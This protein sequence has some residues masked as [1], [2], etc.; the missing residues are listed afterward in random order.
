MNY[1]L[2]SRPN[3]PHIWEEGSTPPPREREGEDENQDPPIQS[4]KAVS[5]Q[6]HRS[7]PSLS[8]QVLVLVFLALFS[9]STYYAVSQFIITAVVVR[10]RSMT[11]TLQDG[12]RYFINRW[13]LHFREPR[14]GD[15]VVIRDTGHNDFAVK[16]IIAMPSESIELR[17]GKVFINGH[18]FEEAYLAPGTQT[19]ASTSPNKAWKLCA[20]QYFVMGDN[21]ANSEDSRYYGTLAPDQ[22]IGV[23][24]Q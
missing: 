11:P 1:F 17:S 7:Q 14:R 12:E 9:I 13:L 2:P 19:Y 20:E 4:V 21:R 24:V 22:I 6:A 16:R 8:R 18:F 3:Q 5:M 23:L 15:V 10:G